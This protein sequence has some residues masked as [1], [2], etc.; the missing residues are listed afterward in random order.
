[1]VLKNLDITILI[2]TDHA[3]TLL[4]RKLCFGRDEEPMELKTKLDWVLMG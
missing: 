1:M 3:D 4:H 2:S